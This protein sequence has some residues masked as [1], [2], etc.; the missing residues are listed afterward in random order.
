MGK[1]ALPK[2][3]KIVPPRHLGLGQPEE[4]EEKPQ[5]NEPSSSSTLPAPAPKV[6]PRL[7]GKA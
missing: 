2:G 5:A 7:R 1:R 6:L 4:T 3:L